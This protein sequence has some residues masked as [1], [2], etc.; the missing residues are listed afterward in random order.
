MQTAAHTSPFLPQDL[1]VSPMRQPPCLANPAHS[2]AL[3]SNTTSQGS[4]ASVL[5]CQA[6]SQA[7]ITGVAVGLPVQTLSLPRAP[8]CTAPSTVP[9]ASR[10]GEDC[11][12]VKGLPENT[13]GAVADGG[14]AEPRQGYLS[15]SGERLV[16]PGPPARG[17]S[18][19]PL[20]YG[21]TSPSPGPVS[22]PLAVDT[23]WPGAVKALP[24][25]EIGLSRHPF[26]TQPGHILVGVSKVPTLLVPS[27]GQLK[28]TSSSSIA[29]APVP[30]D[31]SCSSHR[32]PSLP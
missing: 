15:G 16:P 26:L 5:P 9:V 7:H 25:N 28:R 13:P 14:E 12:G 20:R 24:Q 21:S 30:Q 31:L 19:N 10:H 3:S 18:G 8:L 2:S 1:A 4:A 27:G 11:L 6:L 17:T 29:I 23:L 22:S 32:S